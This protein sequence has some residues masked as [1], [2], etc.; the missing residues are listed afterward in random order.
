MVKARNIGRKIPDTA[1]VNGETFKVVPHKFWIR[2]NREEWEPDLNRF[3]KKHADSSKTVLDIGAWQGPS[4]FT[5]LSW[6]AKKIIAVEA[7]TETCILL[8]TNITSNNLHDVVDLRQCCIADKTM[9]EVPFGPMDCHVEHSSVNGIGGRGYTVE[10][11]SFTDFL[12]KLDLSDINI[13]KIDVEGGE[14]L[15]TAGLKTLSDVPDTAIYLAMHPPFWPDK[16]SVAGDFMDVCKHFDMFD[17]KENPLTAERLW[18]SMMSDEKTIYPNKT[19]RFF[20]IILKS[21]G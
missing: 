5:A 10:T 17:S 20:D 11:I 2:Y 15:L 8:E 12:G 3:F 7:N 18:E 4:L 19:G 1:T 16:K 14:R 13:V 6:K 21:K 9:G